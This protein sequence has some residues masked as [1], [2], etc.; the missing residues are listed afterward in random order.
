MEVRKHPAGSPWRRTALMLAISW[1]GG[2][3]AGASTVWAQPVEEAVSIPAAETCY[4]DGWSESLRCYELAMADGTALSVLVA[5]AVNAGQG[6]PLYLLA[7]GPGQ[8]AS[9]L[10]NLL[11][12]L[13]KVN[14]ERDIVMVD[15]RGAGR[16][17]VFDC[18]LSE[19]APARL[20]RFVEKLA[21]CYQESPERTKSLNSRQTVDDL[22]TVRKALGHDKISLW[23]GSWG[24]RTALLY[25]QWYP[26]SLKRLVLDGVA[27]I[28]TKVF[29]TAKVA[30]ASL[31]QLADACAADPVCAEFGDWRGELDSLLANWSQEQAA[32][33]PDPFT[34]A[35]GEEPVE[36]WM[37]ASAVRTALYD[38][39]ASAQLP[40]AVHEA[41]RGNLL[42]LSGIFGLFTQLEGAMA[43][44]LTFSV[45]CAEEI[46]RV[47]AQ[48]IARD[49]ADTFIGEYFI[50]TFVE[51][52]KRWPVEP[53][54]YSV[55]EPRDQPVLLISGTADPITPPVY[56]DT[57]LDY[58]EN[59][60]H[61]V[62]DG[63]GHINSARGCIPDLIHD[64]LNGAGS[65]DATCVNEIVRPPFMVAAYGPAMVPSIGLASGEGGSGDVAAESELQTAEQTGGE[66]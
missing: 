38:P 6:E 25:Q 42:P 43:M 3:G 20:E 52:C 9:Q 61:L 54:P 53:R 45:A 8:A 33:F 60:Q 63:G 51:G 55:P 18:G 7:G 16:S 39:S 58:L 57:Q 48:E 23:G 28:E 65:L 32:A 10:A 30:E 4:V 31:Q 66:Q 27:P 15:R 47:S 59:K 29:L 40:F 46:N 1:L 37:I 5:P 21:A 41:H 13:R 12:P 49:S 35:P 11:N 50:R 14:R 24:T 19:D 36:A 34:G 22:E 56:A 64:F 62:V 2:V 17:N 44:G 26:E